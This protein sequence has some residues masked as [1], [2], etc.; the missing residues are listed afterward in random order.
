VVSA[1]RT[2]VRRQL[3]AGHANGGRFLMGIA[4]PIT[5]GTPLEHVRAIADTVHDLVVSPDIGS[6]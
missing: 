5:P 4:G 6:V 1:I 2:E 3:D